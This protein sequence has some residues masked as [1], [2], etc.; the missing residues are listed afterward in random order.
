MRYEIAV[1]VQKKTNW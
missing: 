1:T